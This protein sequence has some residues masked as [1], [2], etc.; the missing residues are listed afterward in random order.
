MNPEMSVCM[1]RETELEIH[2]ILSETRK[3]H[4][5]VVTVTLRNDRTDLIY[6]KVLNNAI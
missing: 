4:V 2:V 6:A 3:L 1:N 5:G